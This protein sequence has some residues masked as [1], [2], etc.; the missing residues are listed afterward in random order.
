MTQEEKYK[1]A[2]LLLDGIGLIDDRFIYEAETPYKARGK[3]GF[4]RMLRGLIVATASL[5]IVLSISVSIFLVGMLAPKKSEDDGFDGDGGFTAD[6]EVSYATLSESFAGLRSSTEDLRVSAD[7]VD[8]FGAPKII[9]KYSGEADYRVKE[10]SNS[11]L[12]RITGLISKDKGKK[13]ESDSGSGVLE[14]VWI[15]MGDGRVFTPCLEVTAGN[16]GYGEIFDYNVE[17]EPSAELRDYMYEV[18]SKA[19]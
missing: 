2:D 6:A 16:V 14:G 9:W 13:V 11:E 4:V 3:R 7:S 15:A 19:S 18:I 17:Y 1:Y 10:I 12:E 8:L 5:T